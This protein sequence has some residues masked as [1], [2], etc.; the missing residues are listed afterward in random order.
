ML[1]TNNTALVMIDIQGK[2]WNAMYEKEAL[3]DNAQKLIKGMQAWAF[4]SCSPNKTPPGW[5]PLWPP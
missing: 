2:L 4:P 5:A 1:E 3:L